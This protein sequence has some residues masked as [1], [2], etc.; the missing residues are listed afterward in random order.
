VTEEEQNLAVTIGGGYAAPPGAGALALGVR[1]DITAAMQ[2]RAIALL[3]LGSRKERIETGVAELHTYPLRL[4]LGWRA[5]QGALSVGAGPEL[6]LALDAAR[7]RRVPNADT[8]KR[9]VPG[10]GVGA[11]AGL[12]L[13]SVI[14]LDLDAG[15]DAVHPRL[16]NRFVVGGEEVLAPQWFSAFVAAGVTILLPM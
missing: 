10:L 5:R 11:G 4:R 6:Y 7:A 14:G 9:V 13:S 8:A 1:A 12:R 15:L 16:T 2:L 3:P